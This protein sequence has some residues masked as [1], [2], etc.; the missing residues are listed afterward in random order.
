MQNC[1][2]TLDLAVL[3]KKA[4]YHAAVKRAVDEGSTEE[5]ARD[6]LGTTED[7]ISLRDCIAMM[8][9]PGSLVGCQLFDTNVEF[10]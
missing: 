8:L 10:L 1:S 5:N 2:F 3:D 7:D 9:D 4:L 6:I